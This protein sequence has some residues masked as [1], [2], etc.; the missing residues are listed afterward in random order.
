MNEISGGFEDR[1]SCTS[2]IK[3]NVIEFGVKKKKKN[4]Q[5]VTLDGVIVTVNGTAQL[6]PK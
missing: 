3:G 4:I 6:S 5:K 1:E 2:S